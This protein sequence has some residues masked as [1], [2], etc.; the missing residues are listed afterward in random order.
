MKDFRILVISNGLVEYTEALK[1]VKEY[2]KY[3]TPLNIDFTIA[4]SD[5]D[6][7]KF[8]SFGLFNVGN[9][10]KLE[11][12]GLVKMKDKIRAAK[13][14]NQYLYH[15]VIFLYEFDITTFKKNY[16]NLE[17]AH[18]SYYNEIYPGIEYIEIA[19]SQNWGQQELFRVITHELRHA[20]V[21]KCRRAGI[22]MEDV[23]DSTPVYDEYGNYTHNEAYYNEF[24]VYAVPGNRSTQ[25]AKLWKYWDVVVKNPT[26]L[27]VFLD[28][29][30]KQIEYYSLLLKQVKTQ[31]KIEAW[32]NA[33]KEFE[34]WFVGSRSYRNNSPGN[35]KYV[36]Q[37]KA[38]GQDKD[39]F[40]IFPSYEAGW[41]HLCTILGNC[42]T[43]KS[44][45]YSP[46]M[47]LLEFFKK[48]APSEDHNSPLNYS[49]FVAKKLG[50]SI[51]TKIK[52]LL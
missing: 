18:W 31:P 34:G 52:E 6:V 40:A 30:Q 43:G 12:A 32:A 24:D 37:Y 47:T 39:G 9:D 27:T 22:A 50:V 13:L 33:I 5:L 21:N 45:V 42:A 1:L 51:N 7:S 4:F 26:V 20:Y 29:V 36:G 2:E 11:L 14:V 28:L 17:P 15:A 23:M 48:Y 10:L 44:K 41:T 3:A 49:S 19:H 16:P 46:E 38:I 35:F 8:E 25:D